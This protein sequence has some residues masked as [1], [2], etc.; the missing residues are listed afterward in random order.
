VC[1][2]TTFLVNVY[3]VCILYTTAENRKSNIET[4]VGN[5]QS[6]KVV[7]SYNSFLLRILL[8]PLMLMSILNG[9]LNQ[10]LRGRYKEFA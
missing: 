8:L 9:E 2:I 3:C 1:E 5:N 4:F 6:S 7:K 10:N